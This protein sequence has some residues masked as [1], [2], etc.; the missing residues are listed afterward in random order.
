MAWMV[1]NEVIARL[2]GSVEERKEKC[3]D[4]FC[5]LLGQ[6]L[7]VPDDKFEV[8]LFYLRICFSRNII[9]MAVAWQ[10]NLAITT[11]NLEIYNILQ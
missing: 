11:A 5:N 4:Y 9:Y 7:K 8:T 1:L 6:P 10:R 3:K 2:Q